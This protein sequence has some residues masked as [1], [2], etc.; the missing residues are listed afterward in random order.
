MLKKSSFCF[1]LLFFT[2][3]LSHSQKSENTGM[4]A[5]SSEFPRT[6][7]FDRN[8]FL[9]DSQFWTMCE[10]AKGVFIFGNNDGAVVFDGENWNKIKLPNNSSVRSLVLDSEGK[11]YAGGFNE[12]GTFQRNS[13]GSY[14][15]TSLID[16]FHLEGSN[17]ENLWQAHL[18]DSRIIFRAFNA[19][20][21]ISGNTA[22]QI[23]A[24]RAFVY[25]NVVN[26]SLWV[27]DEGYGL[28]RLDLK[29][30]QLVDEIPAKLFDNET[31]SAILPGKT[32]DE[33]FLISKNGK[34]FKLNT[35]KKSV[36]FWFNL[37][38]EN[39]NDRVT[40]ALKFRNDKYIVSTLNSRIIEFDLKGNATRNN[41][42]FADVKN[43]TI[44]NLF[45]T[46]KNNLWALLNNGLNYLD[47]NS[48]YVQI[49]DQASV[50]D[51]LINSSNFYVA[52]NIGVYQS[53]LTPEFS[54]YTFEKIKNLNGQAWAV[55]SVDG[56]V[57]ISHDDGLYKLQN[58]E[59][60][61]IGDVKGFWKVSPVK[62]Q[63]N[64]FLASN[65]NGLYLLE[66]NQENWVIKNKIY[67]FDES[68]RDILAS[69]EPNTYWVCHG[70][71]GVYRI[72]INNDYTRVN[73]IEHF[74]NQNGLPSFYNVNATRWKNKI[75]FTTNSG[76][77]TF[78]EKTKIFEPYDELNK[79]FDPTQNTR[80]LIEN[81]TKVWFVQD[82]EA[83][84]VDLNDADKKLN[85]DIFLNLKGSFNRGMESIT[86]IDKNK[87]LIGTNTG[88]FLYSI[89]Q[90]ETETIA[91]TLLTKITYTSK[92]NTSEAEI[93][94]GNEGVE[95]P[96][97]IDLLR[98]DFAV[99]ALFSETKAQYSYKLS[100]IDNG[101][102][103]WQAK[104]YKEYTHLRPGQYTFSVKSQNLT[105]VQGQEAT[106]TF[107]ILPKW[108]QT[109]LAIVF[110]LILL[111]L[112]SYVSYNFLH[113]YID[114]KNHEALAEEKKTKK[115]LELEIAQLKLKTENKKITKDRDFLEENV[116][117][118]SKELANYT[119]ML[120]QKKKMFSEMQEDLK[121]LRPTLKSEESRKKV[122]E[123]F[124]KLHQNK[125]GEE[126]MEIFDVNFEKI[127]HNFFEK[128]KKLNPTF[129][130]RELRL[131]AFI[132]MNML[133]KEI[134]SLLNIS[135]RGVESARYRVRK[136]LNVTHDDNL[137]A[138]LENLD[139]KK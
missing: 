124:Q 74:T 118:K 106:Y 81:D 37:F 52:T 48:P 99:P 60:S 5:F 134:S 68:T 87:V 35:L 100:P 53:R 56:D 101:W 105:G 62:G 108:Y 12:I 72:V 77:Y 27:Q 96:N 92:Q 55:Q 139:K 137:V 83:G 120:S 46:R 71:K 114:K 29:S 131:C 135:T 116:I 59:A 42:V 73:A 78:N 95:L 28:Y 43:T 33:L 2:G 26:N 66:K 102:S 34:V 128:L 22:L 69:D 132:K 7:Y 58:N 23:P 94:Q 17:L 121:Q 107:S 36:V 6:T 25:S 109:N 16:K 126:Y 80:K 136:K 39:K 31:L 82:D 24:R 65:Y 30:L 1:L 57:L 18:L 138:F 45:V 119:L 19:L 9:A 32:S 110:Y 51:I 122:T 123:I 104:A 4:S 111:M 93:I 103:M 10:D 112:F 90:N 76:I 125:I 117:E 44:H 50:Y 127:H 85:K 40:F 13:Q 129:T 88:L 20:I 64:W 14:Y 75:I 130:Q 133:N 8:T 98:F 61:K 84:Y 63:S 70:Y 115:L 49:F 11:I 41:S 67:G 91:Q 79:I 113:R 3:L 54:K 21:V 86:P 89:N 47:F 97:Q 15:Y 38:E